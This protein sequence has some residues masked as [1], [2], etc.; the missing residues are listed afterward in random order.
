MVNLWQDLRYGAR[1]LVRKPGFTLVAIITLALSIGANTAIFSLVNAVL[2]R[3]LP[4]EQP[5]QL[6]QVWSVYNAGDRYP[7]SVPDFCDYRDQ[8]QSLKLA[9]LSVWNGNL[10]GNGEPER[11]PGVRISADAFQMLGVKALAGRTLLPPDDQPGNQR[12]VVLSH[13]FWQRRFGAEL[14][15][16]G[17]PLMLNGTNYE[18]VGVLPPDFIFPYFPDVEFAIPLAPDADPSRHVRS[19]TSFLRL[20]ARLNPGVAQPQAEAEMNAISGQLR[21]KYPETNGNKLGVKLISLHDGIV[22]NYRRALWVLF[23]AVALVLLIACANLANLLLVRAA[24]RHKE[25]AIRSALGATRYRLIRQLLIESMLL[26][27]AGTLPGLLLAV[28][29]GELLLRLSPTSLPRAQEIGID[30]DVLAFTIIISLLSGLL[31][32]LAP[33]WQASRADL[34]HGLKEGGKGTGGGGGRNR[35]RSLL[36]MAEVA[37]ALVLL[38]GSG[39][40]I[41]SFQKVQEVN[42]GFDAGNLL[43][44]R[45]ALPQSNYPDRD[46]VAR[47]YEQAESRIEKLPGVQSLAAINIVPLSSYTSSVEFNV[48]GRPPAPR[49]QTP[50]TQYRIASPG[51][52]RTLGIPLMAGRE[53]T[54]QDAASSAPVLVINQRLAQRFFSDGNP[55]GEHLSIDDNDQGPRALEIVGVVGDVKQSGPEGNPTFDIYL[56]LHQVHADSVRFLRTN[57]NLVIR[58]TTD[59]LALS[60]AVRLELQFVDRDVPAS[61]IGTMEQALAAT[62]AP[63]RFNLFL[64]S[65]F[66]AVALLLAAT[67]IYAIVAYSVTQ[68]THEI[69]IRLALGARTNSVLRLVIGQSMKPALI[70]IGIGLVAA[71]ALTRL[72]ASLLFDVSATDPATFA[73]IA[74]LLTGVVLLACY[75]PA[76]RAAKVDP[77]IALR[78]E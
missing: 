4:F 38:I 12:V 8:T 66:A 27:A 74:L 63:R 15:A 35:V 71:F 1:L 64:L 75:F 60:T 2:L 32:G 25:M 50:R 65:I 14:R 23:G 39:L 28:W 52:F 10:T 59:P 19:S 9:A 21:Q 24:G 77:M 33:A 13:G 41:K 7:F 26:A 6:V 30:G 5:D 54:E 34:N 51:Y 18:V 76:R 40:F 49:E 70:G 11:V 42:P 67:G 37:L 36:V 31:F 3:Q 22:G 16:L 46:A 68:R 44:V 17:Q 78:Y 48:V 72:M 53:F 62:L 47:F 45:L 73:L 29:G 61:S 55:V 43:L 69:G 58:T 20:L 56:P 57:L